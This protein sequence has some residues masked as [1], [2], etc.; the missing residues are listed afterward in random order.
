LLK[1]DK[2]LECYRMQCPM[3]EK[4]RG[5]ALGCGDSGAKISILF[6]RPAEDEL[7]FV[8]DTKTKPDGMSVDTW[9]HIRKWREEEI[10]RRRAA[11][12]ELEERF[13]LRGAP[14]RGASGQ[15]LR[16]WALPMA[17]GGLELE[18]CF[19]ENV[20][21]CAAPGHDEKNL[22]PKGLERLKAESCCAHW[23]RALPKREGPLSTLMHAVPD[24]IDV[25]IVSLHPAGLL[26]D[27]GG[28]IVAL[29]LQADTFK[30]ARAF[31][32]AGRKVLVLAGGKAA[33][34][35]LGYG[36][37]VTRWC[38]HFQEETEETWQRR[39]QRIQDGLSINLT[40]S[41]AKSKGRGRKKE[42]SSR[43]MEGVSSD[44]TQTKKR[45]RRKKPDLT[46]MEA[47]NV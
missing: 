23:N 2:P 21:H 14:V 27:K 4:G 29:P 42:T 11:Y 18:D 37:Q 38:G 46:G 47:F 28:G 44:T 5:F 34:W 35:F 20:L 17:G 3:S 8:L 25:S 30:K 22:Y 10:A 45:T 41:R 33:K 39:M 32:K 31:A 7:A 24:I 6:E 12:P 43:P 15:E 26:K 36:E 19:L 16:T 40:G 13:I 9:S 1:N